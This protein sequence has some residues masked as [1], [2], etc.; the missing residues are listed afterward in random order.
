MSTRRIVF[1]CRAL[2]GEALRCARAIQA[3]DGVTLLN[4]CVE[5]VD[6]VAGLIAAAKSFGGVNRIVTAQE[7]LLA[8]VAA[9]NEALGLTAMTGEVVDRVLNKSKLK[10]TLRRAGVATARD[11]IIERA[12]DVRRFVDDVE[13]PIV[14]KPLNGSGAVTTFRI[15]TE[16]QLARMLKLIQPPVIAETYLIGQELCFDTVTIA[17]EP[18]CYSV[19]CYDPPILDALEN[20]ATRWRCVMPRDLSPYKAF[21]DEGL[22]AVRALDVGNAMTHMEGFIDA[23]GRPAGFVDATLRPAGAR[24]GPMFGSAYDVDPYHVWARVAVDDAFDGPLERKYAV[25]TIFLRDLGS[26]SVEIIDGIETVT[27]ELSGTIVES[28]WPRIGGAKSATYT[29]DGFV[30]VRD[31][32]TAVVQN[33]LDFIDQSIRITYSSSQPSETGWSE[34]MDNFRELN[35]PA[36]EFEAAAVKRES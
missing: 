5:D 29:G 14:L 33:A 18:Q 7:T 17:S 10:S 20:Q 3:L 34:R 16:E 15:T 36:W 26:G 27:A 2:A 19:C 25:G 9:A 22:T 21:I 12:E 11:Q 4:V 28:R 1:V 35:K 6:D 32:D 24:I 23:S 31:A 30:T 13:F 8:T